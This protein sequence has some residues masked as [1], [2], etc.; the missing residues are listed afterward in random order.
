MD[1]F[2][3]WRQLRKDQLDVVTR[4]QLLAR[5]FTDGAIRAQVDA[6][7]WQRLHDGVYALFSG[8]LS[9]EAHRVAALLACRGAALL[10]HE[11]AGELHGFIRPDPRRPI[12]LTV[13]YGTSAFRSEGLHVHR[14][15]AFAHIGVVGAEPPL[16]SK[17]HTVL[18]LAV[19]APDASEAARLAHQ[20]AVDA[21]VRPLALEQAVELRRPPRHRRA[22]A[23]AVGLLRSG[24][25]SE[26]ER[27]YLQDVEV[28]H[29]LPV[30]QRQAP[31]VV[32]GVDRYEDIAYDLPG[33]RAIVR[34][35]GFGYHRDTFT[36]LTDRRRSVAAAVAGT[37]SI[38]YGWTEV[39]KLPCRTAREVETV[40][41]PLGWNE[42]L[43]C[44]AR[45]RA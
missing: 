41:R 31:V 8:P 25:L 3:A 36:A 30:G 42:Q 2:T 4:G 11:T 5:G 39:T 24:V 22:I 26:L 38:P 9:P 17:V 34:L 29:G 6:D 23:D 28:A 45:C 18:D 20:L 44:C 13:P 12:H 43:L 14:S 16:T 40:L 32:D 33:G 27:R 10:S 21:G 37:P 19:A 15:R 35:D 1:E 7:R